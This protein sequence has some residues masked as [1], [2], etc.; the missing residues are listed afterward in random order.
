[1]CDYRWPTSDVEKL[2]TRI[3]TV[4]DWKSCHDC[5]RLASVS[6]RERRH[7]DIGVVTFNQSQNPN[8]ETEVRLA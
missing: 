3:F 6:S 5:D 4:D 8:L 2:L 7:P 1:M